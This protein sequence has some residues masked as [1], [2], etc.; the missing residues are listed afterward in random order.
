MARYDEVAAALQA[1]YDGAVEDRL[2]SDVPRWKETER[3]QFLALLR[4]EDRTTLLEI[5]C[6][7]GVHG[8]WFAA[9]GLDVVCTD[10]SPAM[11]DHCRSIGL[12]AEQLHFLRLGELE[13]TFDAVFAMNCL[14]HVPR[15]ALGDVLRAVR[16]VLVDDGVFYLGQYGGVTHDGP[17]EQ[18]PGQRYF[19]WLTDDDLVAEAAAVF[20]VESF[21]TVELDWRDDAHFQS[22][23]LRST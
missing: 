22:L 20:T 8:E 15:E 2:A 1:S 21:H 7:T 17:F 13:R 5:G 3:D 14:L 11:V 18:D 6:G 16:S 19:S 12:A 9:Q 10:N 4:A 23:L